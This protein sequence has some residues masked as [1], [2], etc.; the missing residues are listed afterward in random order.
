MKKRPHIFSLLY[1]SMIFMVDLS[2]GLPGNNDLFT[3]NTLS[4]DFPPP[5]TTRIVSQKEI[6]NLLKTHRSE[7]LIVNFW[8]TW[9][10]PCVKELPAFVKISHDYKEA[11][12]RVVGISIDFKS[13]VQEQVIPFLKEKKIPYSNIVFYGPSE[14]LINFFSDEWKGDIPATFFYD[15]SGNQ[16]GSILESIEYDELKMAV[17]EL[18]KNSALN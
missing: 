2:W 16:V 15:R 6:E 9:C 5:H 12:V 11:D 7:L 13:Q 14:D 8:A 18:R 4:F 1:L 3:S 17:K 10:G